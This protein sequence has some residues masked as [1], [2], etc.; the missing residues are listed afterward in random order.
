MKLK[1]ICL[2]FAFVLVFGCIDFF[3]VDGC[4]NHHLHRSMISSLSG[5]YIVMQ[6]GSDYSPGRTICIFDKNLNFVKSMRAYRNFLWINDTTFVIDMNETKNCVNSSYCLWFQDLNSPVPDKIIP[7]PIDEELGYMKIRQSY[8]KKYLFVTFAYDIY[9]AHIYEKRY[10]RTI[11]DIKHAEVLNT[12]DASS[13]V[14][15]IPR[16]D[17][18]KTG[19]TYCESYVFSVE[20]YGLYGYD[21]VA[22]SHDGKNFAIPTPAYSISNPSEPD[23][24]TYLGD[25]YYGGNNITFYQLDASNQ[26]LEPVK[27]IVLDLGEILQT[28]YYSIDKMEFSPDDRYIAM[29]G[30]YSVSSGPAWGQITD[31]GYMIIVDTKTENTV[32]SD[33]GGSLG[34]INHAHFT[35]SQDGKL[36][37]LF[38]GETIREIHEIDPENPVK[39]KS[40]WSVLSYLR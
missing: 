6:Y 19:I 25:N 5:E 30:A 34:G 13:F 16:A 8:D 31:L 1:L 26:M 2:I 14:K 39:E 3:K 21:Y 32:F 20:G 17:C 9:D 11:V 7:L 33:T 18:Y 4:Y 36:L 23:Q 10:N 40:W 22:K 27:K 28:G 38:D 12:S 29:N 35:W 37:Y 24:V 15:E